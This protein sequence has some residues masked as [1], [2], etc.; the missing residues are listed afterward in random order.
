M[1]EARAGGGGGGGGEGGGFLETQAMAMTHISAAQRLRGLLEGRSAA[2]ERV[3]AQGME[4]ASGGLVVSAG[5]QDVVKHVCHYSGVQELREENGCF[6]H[7]LPAILLAQLIALS[8]VPRLGSLCT[9]RTFC[10]SE[11]HRCKFLPRGVTS[12]ELVPTCAA[13]LL[14]H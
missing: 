14:L 10:L 4:A 12:A 3:R 7:Y 6:C 5:P 8:A 1:V 2:R 11:W 9:L 13:L